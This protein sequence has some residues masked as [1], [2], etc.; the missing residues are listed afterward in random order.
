MSPNKEEGMVMKDIKSL[1]FRR[2]LPNITKSFMMPPGSGVEVQ[3]ANKVVN[4]QGSAVISKPKSH[5]TVSVET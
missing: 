2:K 3:H 4:S 1:S 5:G